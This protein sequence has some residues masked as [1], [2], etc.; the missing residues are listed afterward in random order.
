MPIPRLL[1]GKSSCVSVTRVPA[2]ANARQQR[3]LPAGGPPVTG[4]DTSAR[5]ERHKAA[6]VD[7]ASLRPSANDVHLERNG[8]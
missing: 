6:V 3:L 1:R 8:A 4:R 5:A 7:G 2:A